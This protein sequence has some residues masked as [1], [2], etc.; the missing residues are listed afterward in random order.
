MSAVAGFFWRHLGNT[1]VVRILAHFV[2][3]A[4]V[5]GYIILS[6]YVSMKSSHLNSCH[7]LASLE[8]K[9]AVDRSEEADCLML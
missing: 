4:H 7:L 5:L 9:L 8:C 6:I 1:R 3:P 2:V